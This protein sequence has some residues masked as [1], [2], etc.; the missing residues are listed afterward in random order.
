[1]VLY[2]LNWHLT[3][4]LLSVQ[5]YR[6]SSSVI[7]L[8]HG[9]NE[10]VLIPVAIQPQKNPTALHRSRGVSQRASMAARG[11]GDPTTLSQTARQSQRVI[12]SQRASLQSPNHSRR[13]QR[14]K[15][16]QLER[17]NVWQM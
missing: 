2:C 6:N 13:Q 11:G 10:H 12:Q 16:S 8:Q 14:S 3:V 7:A 5:K 9:K 17:R 15:T 1:M 4:L